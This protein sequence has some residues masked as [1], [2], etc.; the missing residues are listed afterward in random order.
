MATQIKIL[1]T[2]LR[3]GEQSP[4]CSMNLQEKLEVA[5]QLERLKVDII[6][7]G[8]AIASPGDLAAIKAIS[9][10]VK[11]CTI[12]SLARS[13]PKDIDLAWEAVRKAESPRI[14]IFIATSD[15]HMQ[16][17]LRKTPDQVLEQATEMTKYAKKYCSDI[18][19]SAEDATRSD[20]EFLYRVFEAVIDAGATVINIPDTVGYTT[21][22]EFAEL[23]TNIKNNV[24]NID[25]VELSVHCHN[26]LGLAVANS[27]AAI[28]A[29][30]HQVECTINGIG[31]RAGNAALEEIVMGLVTRYDFYQ[32]KTNIF[33]PQIYRTSKLVS[34]LTGAHVQANK[35]IV[36]ANAFA[37]ESGIH[38]HGVL[39]NKSTYE[40]MTPASIGLT[41]NR[42][43][44]GKHSGRHAVEDRLISLGY[45]LTKEQLDIA[46]EQFKKL[47]DKK[48]IVADED[49]EALVEQKAVSIPEVYKLRSFVINSGNSITA[50]AAVRLVAHGREVE[51]VSTG[52]GPIDAAFKAIDKI[53]GFD[54]SL[55]SFSLQAVTKGKDALGEVTIKIARG[56]KH[57]NGRGLSMDVIEASVLAYLNA[58]N[59][60]MDELKLIKEVE[61]GSETSLDF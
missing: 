53:V 13:L 42:M 45:N 30:V 5:K 19:F 12:A 34:S 23:I 58:I 6:E 4:G 15:I 2:T 51:E 28:R 17:K 43:V 37:H 18:E 11:E 33:T 60:M 32:A 44:L 59:K 40:I 38:Q 36:G 57:Y 47:A 35:A 1:D 14:H 46:F 52:D 16:Y 39:A 9:E 50:T 25:Q 8:F 55:E 21:P 61:S 27:L 41:E 31:E 49:L 3:D 22:W 48:K 7:A 26:D 56:A 54:F 29:G 24:P 10:T 20:P